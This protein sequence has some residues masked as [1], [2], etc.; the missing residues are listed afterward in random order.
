MK[1]NEKQ[2][3]TIRVTDYYPHNCSEQ[4]YATV[5]ERTER[6]MCRW[7]IREESRKRKDRR[8]KLRTFDEMIMGECEG[9]YTPS[10]EESICCYTETELLHI[11]IDE[12]PDYEKEL[13]K[14]YYF[15]EMNLFDLAE[16]YGFSK[17]SISRDSSAFRL[18]IT[19]SFIL[20]LLP[21]VNE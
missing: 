2:D 19:K 5:S 15:D 4:K 6:Y 16:I 18:G 3:V 8:Y 21:N 14:H 10:H 17:E 12:L 9:A 1:C 20:S 11:A 7:E 13:I